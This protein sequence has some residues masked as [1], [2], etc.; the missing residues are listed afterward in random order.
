ME[1]HPVARTEK[2]QWLVSRAPGCFIFLLGLAAAYLG[3]I[4][5]LWEMLNGV[6]FIT[7]SQEVVGVAILALIVGLTYMVFGQEEVNQLF[8]KPDK[9]GVTISGLVFAMFIVGIALLGI[10]MWGQLVSLLGYG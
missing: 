1:D 4:Q 5:P 7:Y 8:S 10:W 3:I 2:N 6:D 9:K